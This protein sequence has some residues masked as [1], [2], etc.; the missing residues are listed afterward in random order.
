M[1]NLGNNL[2]RGNS[3]KECKD[4]KKIHS[5]PIAM[6]CVYLLECKHTQC[7]VIRGIECGHLIK[8]LSCALIVRAGQ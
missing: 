2:G 4:G 7:L 8:H 6:H 3:N 1:K 5:I